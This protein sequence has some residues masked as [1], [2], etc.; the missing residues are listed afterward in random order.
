MD[1]RRIDRIPSVKAVMTPFPWY[2][3]AGESLARASEVMAEHE[4]RHL[5]VTEDGTLVGVLSER[6]VGA[7]ESHRPG[8]L[9]EVTGRDVCAMD[10]YVVELTAPLDVVLLGMAERRIGSA[11]V[12]KRGKL[13]GILTATDACRCFGETL[14]DSF[15]RGGG[16]AA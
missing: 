10:A 1:L 15:A 7:A 12:A 8:E 16:D 3:D 4:I 13:V 5:P 6:D 2:V 14:R 9:G 11:L